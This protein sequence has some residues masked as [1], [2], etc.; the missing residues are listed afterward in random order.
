LV[1]AAQAIHVATGVHLFS[2]KRIM[3]WG[4]PLWGIA[5]SALAADIHFLIMSDTVVGPISPYI[6]GINDEEPAGSGA[7]LRRLGGNRLTGYN[8]VNN[9]SNAGK[10][11]NHTSDNWLCDQAHLADGDQPGALAKNFIEENQKT[12]MESLVTLPMAGYVAADKNGEVEEKETAP[13]KRWKPVIFHKK[14]KFTLAP[15]PKDR[16]V[17]DDEFVN[18]LV[19]NYK[20]AAEGGV[21]FYDLDNEPGIWSQTH[22]RIHPKP[23]NYWEMANLTERLAFAV[24]KVDPTAQILGPVSYGWQEFLNL[25]NSPDSEEINKTEGTFLDFYLRQ[26]KALEG[27]DGRRLLHILDLHWYP[28]VQA[29]S[30]RITEGDTSPESVE[31]R[32]QAPRSLWDPGYVEKSWITQSSTQ[33]KPIQL[34]PWLKEKIDRDYPGTGLGFSEYDYGAGEHVSGGLAQA[35]ALGIF[36]KYGVTLAA[37]GGKL[38]SYNLAAFHLYRDYDGKGSAFGNTEVSSGS[39]DITQ[40][41]VYAATDSK[42]PGTLWVVV[43]NKNQKD[44]LSGK[45]EIQGKTGYKTWMRY[46]F[47]AQSTQIK[48][49][50]TGLLSQNKFDYSLPPLSANLFICE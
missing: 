48:P 8:W 19:S 26:M 37:F 1:K 49:S 13:S 45:F 25:Q 39:D 21:K 27:H 11:W 33:G 9:A 10:D 20:T 5:L 7:T 18:F 28:E 2:I 40:T 34:I 22:P 3:T 50:G 6:Y 43:L 4:I 23:T 38:K 30:K 24:T 44:S 29:N 32:L 31:A 36:G 16:F 47:D 42:R 12:G 46:G 15:H 14:G 41:S 17:Y 35:D